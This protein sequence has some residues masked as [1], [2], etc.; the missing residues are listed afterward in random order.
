MTNIHRQVDQDLQ[1]LHKN[2][3]LDALRRASS[4]AESI[5]PETVAGVEQR[6]EL[7]RSR[8]NALLKILAA[9]DQ[10]IDPAFDP[11]DV[12]S[13]TVA[14]PVIDGVV[15]DSGIDPKHIKNPKVRKAYEQAID[16]NAQKARRYAFQTGLRKIDAELMTEVRRIISGPYAATE[17]GRQEI[18]QA[19]EKVLQEPDRRVQL[20]EVLNKNR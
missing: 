6:R 1:D 16:R 12:P 10:E 19:L 2:K 11:K 13:S 7:R 8:L 20:E 15:L 4:L 3:S 9:I 5:K 18:R 14:P 17:P